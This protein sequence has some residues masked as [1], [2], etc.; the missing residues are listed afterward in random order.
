MCTFRREEDVSGFFC[1]FLLLNS[2]YDRN[3][4]KSI[5]GRSGVTTSE[6]VDEG[7]V[8]DLCQTLNHFTNV[9]C[10]M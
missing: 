8:F 2:L 5:G 6:W 3:Y 1:Y 10:D 9:A 7:E 4:T